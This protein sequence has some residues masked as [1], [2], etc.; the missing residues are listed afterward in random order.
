MIAPTQNA[1]LGIACMLIGMFFISLNDMVVK[2]L[3]G[4]YPLHQI[5]FVRTAL[6]IV[7]STIILQMEGGFS[8]LKTNRVGLH[9]LR[10]MLIVSGNSLLYAAIA[11]MPLAT[12]NALYFV[13]PLFVTLLSVPVLGEKVGPRRI[14]AVAVGFLGVLLMLSPQLRGSEG[15]VGWVAVLPIFAAAC[16]AGMSVLTRKL[17]QF[18]RASALAIYMQAAFLMVSIA[19]YLIAGDGKFLKPDSSESTQFLLRAW[20]WP[21]LSDLLPMLGLGVISAV[22]GYVMSQAYRLANAAVVAPFEYVLLLFALFWGWTIFGE[23]P[24]QEVLLGAS[25]I[26]GAGIY[27]FLREN[28]R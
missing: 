26:I 27:I 14:G 24:E 10:A 4:A 25:V 20:I 19:F 2:T 7:L 6:G 11:A 12:A 8:L 1:R 5:L 28:R 23:W 21:P 13:A 15:S 16:Y 18:S 17:G 9:V 3:S 22:V